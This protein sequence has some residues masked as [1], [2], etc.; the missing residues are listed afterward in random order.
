MRWTALIPLNAPA[1]RKSRLSGALAA[2]ERVALSEALHR[3]VLDCVERAGICER[4]LT[5]SP[6][7]AALDPA[8]WVQQERDLNVELARARGLLSAP[9]LVLNADLPVLTPEDLRALA[10]AA[11]SAGSAVAPDRHGTGTN[12]TALLPHAPFEFAFGRGSL[13][14]HLRAAPEARVVCRAGLAFDLDTPADLAE[15]ITSGHPLPSA[16]ESCLRPQG[17]AAKWAHVD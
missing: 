5:L 13:A 7:L 17:V 14:A 12:A 9:L 1:R 10:A 4:V 8:R 2:H 15:L 16:L 6:A 3:H 11:E